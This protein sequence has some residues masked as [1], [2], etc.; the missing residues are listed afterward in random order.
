[1]TFWE[2]MQK[3]PDA[4][5][6]MVVSGALFFAEDHKDEFAARYGTYG[7]EGLVELMQPDK[8]YDK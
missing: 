7:L 6:R 4:K 8:E 5:M 3:I 2:L 1:M